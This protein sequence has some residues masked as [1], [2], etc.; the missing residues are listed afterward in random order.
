MWAGGSG[1]RHRGAAAERWRDADGQSGAGDV[2]DHVEG[3]QEH[4]WVL[5]LLGTGLDASRAAA[6]KKFGSSASSSLP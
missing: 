6:R 1:W 3:A 5:C 2:N 4:G